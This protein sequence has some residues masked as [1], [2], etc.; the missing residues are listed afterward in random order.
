MIGSY[1][2]LYHSLQHVGSLAGFIS[3]GRANILVFLTELPFSVSS[4]FRLRRQLKIWF[5]KCQ[6]MSH[7]FTHMQI[8][9]TPTNQLYPGYTN[10]LVRRK[11][12]TRYRIPSCNDPVCVSAL[13]EIYF[14]AKSLLCLDG[15]SSN[16]ILKI[17]WIVSNQ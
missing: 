7:Y 14:C 8:T 6:A 1:R 5:I 16:F 9:I 3:Q 11:P 4:R 2:R 13:G 10:Y 17:Y 15:L 12:L